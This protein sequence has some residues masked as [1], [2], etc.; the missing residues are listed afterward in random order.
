MQDQTLPKQL[1][2]SDQ[3]ALSN[4][5]VALLEKLLKARD[6][7]LRTALHEHIAQ[8]SQ[9]LGLDTPA[10][11]GIGGADPLP[12]DKVQLLWE[13][14][15]RLDELGVAYNHSH[16]P[17]NLLALHWLGLHQLF[18]THGIRLKVDSLLKQESKLSPYPAF[19]ANKPVDSVL[20]GKSVRCFV[21]SLDKP[22]V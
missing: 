15:R 2:I 6:R 3:I 21:F 13:A 4:H 9:Q 8:V 18:K 12:T 5:R 20:D 22:K 7:G 14:L 11:E 17:A 1:S 10:L 19:V 16:K